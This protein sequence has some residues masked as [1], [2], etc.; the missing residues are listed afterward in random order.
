MGGVASA[1]VGTVGSIVAS[2]QAGRAE[3]AARN[4]QN[5]RQAELEALEAGRQPIVNPYSNYSD[6]S[7]M[8][9]NLG[10]MISNPYAN[11]GVATQAAQMQAEEADISLANTL[12]TLRATGAGAGG[13][14]ALAQAALRSKKGVAASIESQEAANEK[15]AAQGQQN[16]EQMQMRESQRVQ[17]I[18]ISE[19][20]RIQA[21]EAAGADYMF[22]AREGR[23]VA[24]MD[25]VA[26]Y[27]NRAYME[28]MGAK[29]D[30][31]SAQAGIFSG[32][33]SIAGSIFGG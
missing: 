4:E 28:K 14:T 3:R 11:L 24:K 29:A 12:D 5:R 25:R 32:I 31:A 17:A 2:G 20:Q 6:L 22:R 16:M 19:G 30:K 1:V 27:E 7:D 8:A 26:G 23:E 10:D 15:L 13:A 9:S 18:Q 21:G 33:G